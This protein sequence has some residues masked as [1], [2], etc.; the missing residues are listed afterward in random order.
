MLYLC[1][2]PELHMAYLSKKTPSSSYFRD[3]Y[4]RYAPVVWLFAVYLLCEIIVYPLGEFPL[5]DDWAYTKALN[6]FT[7]RHEI[8]I[9]TWPAM[10]LLSQI[11]WG[12]VFTEIFGFSFF[13]LRFSTLVSSFIGLVFL[14]KTL[15]QLT[16]ERK[17]SFLGST[18]LL[19]NPLYFNLSNTFMTDVNFNTLMLIGIY[20]CFDYFRFQ[21]NSALIWISVVSI[22]LVLLRQYGILLPFCFFVS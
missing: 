6:T 21:K 17:L 9:G 12:S 1:I 19:F 20:S 4:D 18:A 5:N 22:L 11:L 8:N 14:Y 3:K 7:T 2:R 13:A 10:T 15:H 16:G